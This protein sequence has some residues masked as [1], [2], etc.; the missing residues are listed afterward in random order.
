MA[1]GDLEVLVILLND[2]LK[3]GGCLLGVDQDNV[4]VV[5]FSAR[6]GDLVVV[7]CPVAGDISYGVLEESRPTR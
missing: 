3:I 5:L 7:Q 2:L 6:V 4:Q 1:W